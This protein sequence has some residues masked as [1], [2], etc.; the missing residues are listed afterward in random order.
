MVPSARANNIDP[1]R[2]TAFLLLLA[3]LLTSAC[4]APKRTPN[5]QRIFAEA[6]ARK[7]KRPIIVIPGILGTQLVNSKTGE[8]I[9]PSALRS[10]DESS[11]LPMTPDLA[12]NRDNVVPAKI[13]ETVR[14]AKLLPEVYVYKEL[15]DALRYFGGYREGDW[16]NPGADGDRD[17]FYV[18]PYDFR[19]DNV[20]NARLLI[21]RVRELKTKLQRPDLRFNVLAHS[22]GGLIARYAA[23]Y[24]DSDLPSSSTQPKPNWSGASEINKIVMLGTPNEGSADAFTTLIE[25]YSITE[26]L[27]T[28]IP[29]LNRLTAE[30]SITA[31]A[32]FQLLPHQGVAKFLDENLQPLA[33]DLYDPESWKRYGW[34]PINDPEY[35]RR[36]EGVSASV[37]VAPSRKRSVADLDGYLAAV[38]QRA[39]LFHAALDAPIDGD[40]PVRLFAIGGDCEETFNAPVVMWEAKRNRWITLTRPRDYRTSTGQRITKQAATEAMFAPGDGRV[41]RRSLLGEDL[42]GNRRTGAQFDTPLPL[43]Y[44]VFGCDLHGSLPKNKILADNALTALVNEASK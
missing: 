24:G 7:G 42:L 30:E 33:I 5:L 3:I 39:K 43:T 22:M 26:G 25:G 12:N 41:T 20:E 21:T 34:S 29:L 8:V 2:A 6:R 4:I 37:E 11:N 35:R 19:R 17:T 40:V 16:S 15:L 18:F 31:P 36:Y 32:I 28:R 10:D 13:V 9:W 14:L 38:L 23:M 1:T 27:R 44:A